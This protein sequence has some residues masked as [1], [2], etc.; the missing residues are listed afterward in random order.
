MSCA[1]P[2]HTEKSCRRPKFRSGFRFDGH[3]LHTSAPPGVKRAITENCTAI[4][5]PFDFFIAPL[6]SISPAMITSGVTRAMI[7]VKASWRR[8]PRDCAAASPSA[9]TTVNLRRLFV[10]LMNDRA[11]RRLP[12]YLALS[13]EQVATMKLKLF[14]SRLGD[15]IEREVNDWLVVVPSIR[16]EK[17]ELRITAYAKAKDEPPFI[18]LAVW[19][20]PPVL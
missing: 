4:A 18:V 14:T 19:Y 7:P 20:D 12:R 15:D 5:P 9:L 3:L 13:C 6:M 2:A 11:V 1:E 16:V 17:T 10:R 8:C